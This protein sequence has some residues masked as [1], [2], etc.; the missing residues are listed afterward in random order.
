MG[1]RI[2]AAG[3]AKAAAGSVRDG[4]K[5]VIVANRSYVVAIS[6]KL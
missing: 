3:L 5:L 6:M 1:K 2:D 4:I